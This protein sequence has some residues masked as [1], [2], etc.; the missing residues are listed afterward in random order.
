MLALVRMAP[1]PLAILHQWEMVEKAGNA[2]LGIMSMNEY[3]MA[4]IRHHVEA[5]KLSSEDPDIQPQ[6]KEQLDFPMIC[7]LMDSLVEA[8]R[9]ITDLAVKQV[10]QAVLVCRNACL[11]NAPL[12]DQVKKPSSWGNSSKSSRVSHGKP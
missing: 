1:P 8:T 6:D 10:S 4:A 9:H 7:R 11:A 5:V 2:L 3:F 12:T